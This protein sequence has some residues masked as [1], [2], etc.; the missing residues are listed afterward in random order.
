LSKRQLPYC[1]YHDLILKQIELRKQEEEI[2]KKNEDME[3]LKTK[4]R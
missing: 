1:I 4:K 3:R 2:R